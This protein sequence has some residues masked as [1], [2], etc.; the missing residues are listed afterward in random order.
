MSL[1]RLLWL[2]AALGGSTALLG[3]ACFRQLSPLLGLPA[4]LLL[5]VSVITGLYALGAWRLATLEVVPREGLRLLVG[6][7]WAWTVVSLAMLGVFLGH[8]TALGHAFLVLQVLVVGGLA[9]LEGR[10]LV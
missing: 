4:P 5:V 3:L 10:H 2:D 8:A 9:W 6:A 7:N 1:R